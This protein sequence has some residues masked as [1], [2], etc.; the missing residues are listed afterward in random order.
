[1]EV[2]SEGIQVRCDKLPTPL[3]RTRLQV[4]FFR[5][6]SSILLWTCLVQ[7]FAVWEL[8]HPHLLNG[9]SH[10]LSRVTHIPLPAD[11]PLVYS[12]PPPFLP[13]RVYKSNGFLK[14][15]DFDDIFDVRHFID[16]LRDEVRIIRR[17]P[18][19]LSNKHGYKPLLMPPV[20]WSN[21][22]YYLRQILPLFGKHKV[23]HFNKT[24]SRLANNGLPLELQ[25][26][27]YAYPWWREKE[28]VSEEKRA[29]G[30]CP[31]TP[32]ET[33]LVLRA[34]GF[35]K[36]T[37]FYIASGEIY[38]GERRLAAL[39]A[40]FP[41]IVSWLQ[42]NHH[43]RSETTC[44]VVGYNK[45]LPW[46]GFAVA[47]RL[48]HEKRVGQPTRRKVIVEKPKEEDYFYSNPQECLCES[49][50]CDDLLGSVNSSKT[51]ATSQ[52]V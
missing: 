45:T 38:G 30:L 47:V 25:R 40:E 50:S 8:W 9:L 11:Q 18:K 14:V 6:C 23:I 36:N 33:A 27:R 7:L 3:Q 48:A 52:F 26:L 42:E 21:E 29:H 2:R 24:D 46:D 13:S 22:K 17:L 16:S 44:S 35:D 39:K 32:G 28:I 20:S 19:K 34:L 15:S 12:S 1:M 43:T 31:L 5:V 4:W 49:I 51:E 37:Q 41:R 10:K